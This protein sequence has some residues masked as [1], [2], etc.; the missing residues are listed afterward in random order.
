MG[1]TVH[2]RK[3]CISQSHSLATS[4]TY[5][6]RGEFGGGLFLTAQ[7]RLPCTLNS[8]TLHLLDA[9]HLNQ[10]MSYFNDAE[11]V[12]YYSSVAGGPYPYPSPSQTFAIDADGTNGQLY[13]DP[14]DQ[15]GMV[16]RSGPMVGSPTSLRAATSFGES[17][18]DRSTGWCLT[19]EVQNR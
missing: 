19:R 15:W 16:S 9:L 10:T 12:D 18:S 14:T 7:R 1:G 11:N 6:S 13:A 8:F 4:G 2:G 17:H 3:W 5:L